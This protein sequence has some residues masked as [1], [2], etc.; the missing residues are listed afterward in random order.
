MINIGEMI[1]KSMGN[2]KKK[3]IQL[4]SLMKFGNDESDKLIDKQIK[5]QNRQK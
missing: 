5:L 3:K 1:G 2:K 4:K